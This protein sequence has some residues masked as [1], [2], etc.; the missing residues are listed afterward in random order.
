MEILG[1]RKGCVVEDCTRET[2]V[3]NLC[4]KHY[5]YKYEYG[6]KIDKDFKILKCANPGCCRRK[7]FARTYCYKCH[8][9]VNKLPKNKSGPCRYK[10][11]KKMVKGRNYE[12]TITKE[13]YLNLWQK[14][15]HYCGNRYPNSGCGLDRKDNSRGYHIDNVLPCCKFCNRFRNSFASV[16]E[17]E[18]IIQILIE[19]RKTTDIWK[20]KLKIHK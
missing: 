16:E 18:K 8:V 5:Y 15:C 6:I 1:K 9:K 4:G 19:S 13:E 11:A 20:D 3:G 2:F 7:Q 12:F 17:M 10:E 14:P